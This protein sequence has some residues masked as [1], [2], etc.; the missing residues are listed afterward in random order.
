MRYRAAEAQVY[1][2]KNPLLQMMLSTVPFYEADHCDCDKVTRLPNY[3]AA[4]DQMASSGNMLSVGNIAHAR[5]AR[6]EVVYLSEAL[7]FDPALE[8][9]RINRAFDLIAFGH[10][11]WGVSEADRLLQASPRNGYALE[12]RAQACETL[13][14]TS[15]AIR[16]LRARLALDPDNM[17]T[18]TDLGNLYV[19][20]THDWDA[21]WAIANQLIQQHPHNPYGWM[22]RASIQEHQPRAGLRDTVDYF[23]TQFSD[24]PSLEKAATEMRAALDRQSKT[25]STR[26]AA[27]ASQP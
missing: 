22:L 19:N 15:C 17:P 26:P 14:N 12:A 10:A 11:A 2:D 6:V 4:F 3:V 8:G 5:N 13:G 21:G 18:L 16:D 1:A 20:V 7:R 27:N 9:A 24:A 25:T 23:E